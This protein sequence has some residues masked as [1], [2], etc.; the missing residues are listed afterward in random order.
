MT[1]IFWFIW[2]TTNKTTFEGYVLKNP[3]EIIYKVCS[4]LMY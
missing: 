2:I 1:A 4:F 3:M